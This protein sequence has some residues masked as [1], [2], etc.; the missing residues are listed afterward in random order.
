MTM[1]A[2]PERIQDLRQRGSVKERSRY[3]LLCLDDRLSSPRL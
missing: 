1:V 3:T 2:E